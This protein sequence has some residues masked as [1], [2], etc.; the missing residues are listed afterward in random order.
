MTLDCVDFD[1][2]ITGFEIPEIDVILEEANG[3]ASKKDKY[4]SRLSIR[5]Q[6][7]SRATYVCSASIASFAAIL[8][9][10]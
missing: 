7:R 3:A 1:V 4:Q 8:C 6:S 9:M 5:N 2:T 10:K